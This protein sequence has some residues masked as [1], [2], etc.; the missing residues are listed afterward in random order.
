MQ[1]HNKETKA[2]SD[3]YSI[4]SR[5]YMY[6]YLEIPNNEVYEVDHQYTEVHF[7]YNIA[8]KGV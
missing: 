8:R 1:H 2:N 5:V 7:N 4:H 3:K 6:I